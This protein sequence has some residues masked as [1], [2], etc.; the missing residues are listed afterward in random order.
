MSAKEMNTEI[1]HFVA[2]QIEAHGLIIGKCLEKEAHGLQL[3]F[4]YK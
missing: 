2:H 4:I 3:L 1:P